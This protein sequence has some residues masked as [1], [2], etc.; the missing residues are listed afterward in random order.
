MT[1]SYHNER[2]LSLSLSLTFRA[3]PLNAAV[4]RLSKEGGAKMK[5]GGAVPCCS[6]TFFERA[7]LE[8][9]RAVAIAFTISTT[10]IL[11]RI[12]FRRSELRQLVAV[13]ERALELDRARAREN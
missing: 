4:A 2:Q 10:T 11:H 12:L 9:A 13:R 3:Q 1:S 7:E 5:R 6:V 8:R